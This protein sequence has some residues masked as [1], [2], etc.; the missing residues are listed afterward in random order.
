M[1]T[2]T[3]YCP[4][5]WATVPAKAHVCPACGA[6]IEDAEADLVDKYIAALRHPQAGIRL[7][8]AWILGRMQEARAVPALLAVVAAR[9]NHDP[10][11]L[12]VAVKSLGLIGDRQ[13]VPA[14]AALLAEPGTSFMAR[15]EAAYALADIGGEEAWAALDEA[16]ARDSNERV[17]RAA[18]LRRSF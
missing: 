14:L 13:A 9:G 18:Q 15:V 1:E 6:V 11:L 3:Y 12:S 5:C 8:A 17:R 16:A 7:R 10:Y 4:H 2:L